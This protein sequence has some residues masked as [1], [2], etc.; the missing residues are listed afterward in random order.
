MT[1]VLQN[2]NFKDDDFSDKPIKKYLKTYYLTSTFNTST[3]IYMALSL[4]DVTMNNGILF[5][6]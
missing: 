2:S 6:D 4:N 5:S 3:Y 1:L